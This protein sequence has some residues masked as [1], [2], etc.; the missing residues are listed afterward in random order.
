MFMCGPSDVEALG[1]ALLEEGE[2][3]GKQHGEGNFYGTD[4]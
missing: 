4:L 1:E 2:D 3:E